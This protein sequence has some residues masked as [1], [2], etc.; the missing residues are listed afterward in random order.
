MWGQTYIDNIHIFKGLF[1]IPA[2]QDDLF[3]MTRLNILFWILKPCQ[4]L[5][6]WFVV[7]SVS[8]PDPHG[9]A[10]ILDGR[11]RIQGSKIYPQ[12]WAC[13]EVLD[14]FF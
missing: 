2:E 12:K 8:V 7:T 3:T 6:S 10:L 11:I 13:F 5:N 4:P 9:S 14:V 1:R